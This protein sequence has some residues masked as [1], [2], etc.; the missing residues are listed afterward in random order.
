MNARIRELETVKEDLNKRIDVLL[1]EAA[2]SR[3]GT[4]VSST[5]D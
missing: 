1:A 4:N 3:K 5:P 2:P